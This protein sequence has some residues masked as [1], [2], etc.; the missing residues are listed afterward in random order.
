MRRRERGERDTSPLK[1]NRPL[2]KSLLCMSVKGRVASISY[3][4]G[5]KNETG[6]RKRK[7]EKGKREK[8]KGKREKGKRKREK[9]RGKSK[10]GEGEPF[11]P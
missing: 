9:G 3:F 6:E 1:I 7:E 4:W 2:P 8:G 10:R 11:R 5:T